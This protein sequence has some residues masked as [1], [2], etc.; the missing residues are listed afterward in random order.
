MGTRTNTDLLG[1]EQPLPFLLRSIRRRGLRHCFPRINRRNPAGVNRSPGGRDG[2]TPQRH[3]GRTERGGDGGRQDG[4]EVK[5]AEGTRKED[6]GGY[7]YGSRA[8]FQIYSSP[9]VFSTWK[10]FFPRLE[11]SGEEMG[12]GG[13]T[14]RNASFECTAPHAPTPP[15]LSTFAASPYFPFQRKLRSLAHLS[16]QDASPAN[17][18]PLLAF[19]STII[20]VPSRANIVGGKKVLLIFKKRKK[21][22]GFQTTLSSPTPSH[23]SPQAFLYFWQSFPLFS[24][25]HLFPFLF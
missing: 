11:L 20:T 1:A 23:F 13:N 9:R 8:S 3:K 18:S 24:L 16:C 22:R 4:N 10:L 5:K 25:I 12:R 15:S 17:A 21:L 7:I 19:S 14:W 6:R 2:R